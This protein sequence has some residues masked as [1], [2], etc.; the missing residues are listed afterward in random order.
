MIS[1]DGSDV[2]KF[3]MLQFLRLKK[4]TFGE[5]ASGTWAIAASPPGGSLQVKS[6]AFPC[7]VLVLYLK[8]VHLLIYFAR[9]IM[10]FPTTPN[11]VYLDDEAQANLT[12]QSLPAGSP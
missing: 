11:I 1:Y 8:N 12:Y 2:E 5:V 4:A 9:F 10:L 3:A 7:S 6:S